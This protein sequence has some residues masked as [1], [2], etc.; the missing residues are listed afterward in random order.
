MCMCIFHIWW[1]GE[2]Y[3]KSIHFSIER[4]ERRSLF[5]VKGE[6]GGPRGVA[7]NPRAVKKKVEICTTVATTLL[8][9]IYQ[10]KGK[11]KLVV[12]ITK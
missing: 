9:T 1:E 4:F 10:Q 7:R 12:D 8:T 3:L 11:I 6:E 2:D 5:F